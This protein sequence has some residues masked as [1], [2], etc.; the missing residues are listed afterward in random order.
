LVGDYFLSSLLGLDGTVQCLDLARQDQ[1]FFAGLVQLFQGRKTDSGIGVLIG[2]L[3]QELYLPLDV[4]VHCPKSGPHCFQ[5]KE[6]EY[7]SVRGQAQSFIIRNCDESGV[8]D[9]GLSWDHSLPD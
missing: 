8:G 5:I 4:P 9:W 6:L 1:S 7:R 3:D 2:H